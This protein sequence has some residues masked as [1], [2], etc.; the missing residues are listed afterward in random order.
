MNQFRFNHRSYHGSHSWLLIILDRHLILHRSN[1]PKRRSTT[2]QLASHIRSSYPFLTSVLE[3]Y[4]NAMHKQNPMAMLTNLAPPL[5]LVEKQGT[6][7]DIFT[8]ATPNCPTDNS[9]LCLIHRSWLSTELLPIKVWQAHQ[10]LHHFVCTA[11][12]FTIRNILQHSHNHLL[13]NLILLPH[14]N[15]WHLTAKVM[16]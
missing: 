16:L 10:N 8:T 14:S 15:P 3:L 12:Y 11:T 7:V 13:T 2:D 1:S 9:T 5:T 6:P 4:S